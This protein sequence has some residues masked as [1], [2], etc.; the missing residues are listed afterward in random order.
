MNIKKL[1][2]LSIL[3]VV[4]GFLCSTV[5][6]AGIPDK[7]N[8]QKDMSLMKPT[9]T[10]LYQ[11]LNI[12]NITTWMRADGQQNHSPTGDDGSYFPRGTKWVIYQDGFVWGGKA[13]TD[14]G[15]T[16]PAPTQLIRVGGQTYNIGTRAGRIIGTGASAVAQSPADPD[17]RIYRVRRD[18]AQMDMQELIRDASESFEIPVSSVTKSQTDQITNQYAKDWDEWPVAYGAPY[19]ERNGTAGYQKPKPFNYDVTKGAIFNT[20]SLIAHNYDEPGLA[21]AD[22]NSPADQVIWTV[23][24]DL[25]RSAS[26][27]LFGSEPLGLEAQITLWGYKRTDAMGNLYFKKIKFI[28]K[29][30]VDI[31]GGVKG[32]FY[33]DSMFFAQWSDPDLGS[34]GDD[35]CGVDMN[36]FPPVTG[37]PLSLGYVYNGNAIDAEFKKFG[38]QPPAVGYDFLQGP[39]VSGLPTDSGVFNLK[40]VY[41]KKNMPMTSFAYFSA[42]SGISD[43]PF[44]YEGGLRWWRMLQGYVPDAST[45]RWRLYPHPT[46]VPETKFPLNGDP[47]R[48][49]GFI[50]GLGTEWSL[51]PGDR[52]IVLNTGPFTL[53]PGDTQE[54]VVGTVAGLGADRLS[55]INVM[56]FYDQFVQ[57]TYDALF[58]VTPSPPPPAV[59]IAELDGEI[60]LEWGS[61][62]SAVDKTENTISQPGEFVFEGYNVY[63]LPRRSA[64]LAEAKRLTTFDLETEPTVIL[65]RKFDVSSGEILLLPVQFGSNSGITRYFRFNRDHILDIDKLNN[66]QEYYLA[67]TAYSRSTVT[68]FLPTALESSPIIY[69]VRPHSTNPG[70]RFPSAY[71]D[72][73]TVTKTGGSGDATVVAKVI[74]PTA[75]KTATYDIGWVI[76]TVAGSPVRSWTVHEG[77]TQRAKQTNISG[78][79]NYIIFDGM[80]VNVSKLT[81]SPPIT[82]LSHAQTVPPTGG[83]LSLWGDYTVFGGVTGLYKSSMV[84]A[85]IP[86]DPVLTDMQADL[87]IRFTG[88]DASGLSNNDAP[89]TTGGQWTT[90]W[91]RTS[92]GLQTVTE[93]S[94]LNVQMRSS[95]ELW[96]IENNRQLNYALINRNADGRAPYTNFVGD[97]NTAGQ[98]PR[99]R[100]TG[101]DY[102]V[103]IYTPYDA[104]TAQTT[105]M[106]P[107]DQKIGW[108]LFFEQGGTSKW[109]NGDVYK[110]KFANPIVAGTDMYQ[111]TTTAPTFSDALAKIDAQKV[112]V[113]PNPYYAFNPAETNRFVRFVTFNKLPAKAT[114]RIFNLAGQLVRTLTKEDPSQF[115]KWDLN[116]EHN[117]PVASGIYIAHVDMPDVGVTKIV[118]VAIIQ[119]QEVPDVF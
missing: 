103:V 21:G 78:D 82:I 33:I 1:K 104:A 44:N 7:N 48:K 89:I 47:V 111:F 75:L 88:N 9:G 35:L 116:N 119:E 52:R 27:G 92:F 113:Y 110:V 106:F 93:T 96:D 117:F 100:M 69:T 67:V 76:D 16:T 74:D 17:V 81:Y 98:E 70:T 11:I 26:T 51:I 102:I 29:G 86:P 108:L 64:S 45:A 25:D 24:N 55:S 72:L 20:D 94:H 114:I 42:G 66:G 109:K 6:G 36:L 18:Y 5:F 77:T 97:P 22:P 101:R 62:L 59:K 73:V 23:I 15:L 107:N 4:F 95:F 57:T 118:K 50:D 41:G 115:F 31:G 14:S 40:R 30:G 61:N 68:D 49:T 43:P 84:G 2:L 80:Q 32:S 3:V 13:Y 83:L 12:N 8:R 39:L 10:P 90:Q 37:K 46:G 19:I 60:V 53:A 87:E 65:D 34:Y 99:Y 71:G 63:Q 105:R 91:Q 85:D 56:K 54:V 58:Q 112:G 79:E 38:L 28:N